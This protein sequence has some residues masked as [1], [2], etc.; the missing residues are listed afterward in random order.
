M[1]SF[2][3]AVKSFYSNAYN[4]S[5]R[6]TRAEYW[7]AMAHLLFVAVSIIIVYFVFGDV[8]KLMGVS[9]KCGL[10]GNEAHKAAWLMSLL[11]IP[12][13]YLISLIVPCLSLVFRRLHDIGITAWVY[14]IL[15]G[16]GYFSIITSYVST[17]VLLALMILPGDKKDNRYG[18]NP[19]VKNEIEEVTEK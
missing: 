13:L 5:G 6:A 18:V 15:F 9:L 8:F 3:E 14:L 4:F 17:I 2:F 11:F 10:T 16:L 19:Y 1:V 12:I 7:W